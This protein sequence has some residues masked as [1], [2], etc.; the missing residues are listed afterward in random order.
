[1]FNSTSAFIDKVIAEKVDPYIL[2]GSEKN[3]VFGFSRGELTINEAEIKSH[4]AHGFGLSAH[5]LYGS[6]KKLKVS[7]PY[8]AMTNIGHDT[9][10]VSLENLELVF[11]VEL[12][13]VFIEEVESLKF[14]DNF[15]VRFAEAHI[16]TMS[17]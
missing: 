8:S 3:M 7:I 6:M 14:N 1:M 5:L 12:G 4:T 17:A 13:D 10:D 9:T 2:P 15:L 16:I 11:K